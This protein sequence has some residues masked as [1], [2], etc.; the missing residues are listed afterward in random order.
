MNPTPPIWFPLTDQ[1]GETVPV[2]QNPDGMVK[3]FGVVEKLG[4]TWV[5]HVG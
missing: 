1:G 5:I 3:N 2:Y 4:K